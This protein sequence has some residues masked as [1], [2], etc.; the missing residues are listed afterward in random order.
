METQAKSSNQL[1]FRLGT[2]LGGLA[3]IAALGAFKKVMAMFSG[4]R[5]S[6]VLFG[7]LALQYSSSQVRD[8]NE[9]DLYLAQKE[10][11]SPPEKNTAADLRGRS[12][13]WA[14]YET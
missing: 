8:S 2:V 10:C 3:L 11:Y 13:R 14:H 7:F 4:E 1:A 6:Y 5:E 12:R 9:S